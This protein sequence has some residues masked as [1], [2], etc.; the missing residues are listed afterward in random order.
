MARDR[1]GHFLGEAVPI[2]RQRGPGRHPRDVGGAHHD[3]AEPPHLLLQQPDGIIE[4][5]A[6]KRIA[7]DQ[8]RQLAGLVDR[9]RPHA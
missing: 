6:A 4:L 3:G 8:F 1:A 5:V 2:H 7:A 9:G